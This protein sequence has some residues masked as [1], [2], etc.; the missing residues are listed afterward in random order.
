MKA[1][2]N[3]AH[4][5][6]RAFTGREFV[7]YEYRP[8]PADCYDEAGRLEVGGFLELQHDPPAAPVNPLEALTVKATPRHSFGTT[9]IIPWLEEVGTDNGS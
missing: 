2:A 3:K 8:V 5:T 4:G 1:R 9:R 7:S 6:V